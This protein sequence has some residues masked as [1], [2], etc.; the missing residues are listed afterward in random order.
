MSEWHLDFYVTDPSMDECEFDNP[1]IIYMSCEVDDFW[2]LHAEDGLCAIGITGDP[3]D[4]PTGLDI[5]KEWV[6]FND[7]TMEQNAERAKSKLAEYLRKCSQVIESISNPP[8]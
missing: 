5:I 3:D 8:K 4:H 7:L 1:R 6:E 2:T